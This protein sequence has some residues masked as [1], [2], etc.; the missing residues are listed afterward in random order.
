MNILE[1]IVR[2]KK[3]EVQHLRSEYRY[4]HFTD[5]V[6][7]KRP[8]LS[9]INRLTADENISIIAEIKK[10]LGPECL[11]GFLQGLIQ[12]LIY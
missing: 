11:L 3:K 9:M 2:V 7:F 8:V 4:R 5:S 6:F 10:G 12:L 1:E